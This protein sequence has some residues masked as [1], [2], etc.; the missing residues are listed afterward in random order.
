MKKSILAVALTAVIGL[1]HAESSNVTLWGRIDA[2]IAG[3]TNVGT[4]NGNNI[5][6]LAS[7]MKASVFGIRAKEDLGGG[8][9]AG[10]DL[11]SQNILTSTGNVQQDPQ[12]GGTTPI[13]ARSANV[14]VKSESLGEV[15]LGR[16]YSVLNNLQG[17]VDALG[18]LNFGS[19]LT[20]MND[21]TSFGGGATKAGIANYSGGQ[22]VSS[23]ITYTT[24][25]FAGVT[26][27]LQYVPGGASGNGAF[28]D[29]DS[30]T[31]IQAGLKYKSGP[32]GAV[33]LYTTGKDAN[34]VEIARTAMLGGN[35]T[36]GP[37]TVY[38][39]YYNLRNPSIAG[40][41]NSE[42]DVYT[43]SGKYVVKGP[44]AVSAGYYHLKDKVNSN[45]GADQYTLVGTYDVS[46]RTQFY[47][48]LSSVN[49]NGTSGFSP[50]GGGGNNLNS[51]F[52][53][54]ST[55]MQNAGMVQT[56]YVLGMTH[57]F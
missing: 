17:Q 48:G 18:G 8:M 43:V 56:G 9:T 55:N 10:A 6:M 41:A 50:I 25:T 40:Q 31:K 21:A 14:F 29:A 23:G 11:E 16:Q 13:F 30:S 47:A 52:T 1:A 20:F 5:Q 19:S 12:G 3:Q 42:F 7:P 33:A 57:S 36:V 2:G 26:G 45:N 35:Y 22:F 46:K 51:Q 27:Q 53:S 15:R 24:P 4:P 38:A 44:F 54:G 28:G 37:A 49:N 34:G 39:G 32:V